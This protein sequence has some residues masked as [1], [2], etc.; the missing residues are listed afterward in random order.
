MKLKELCC[1]SFLS[2]IH[3]ETFSQLLRMRDK[4]HLRCLSFLSKIHFETFSQPLCALSEAEMSELEMSRNERTRIERRR[5]ERNKL[6]TL[7]IKDTACI[8]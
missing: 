7:H 5:N 8:Q 2:K 1:L 3:F 6:S 4:L